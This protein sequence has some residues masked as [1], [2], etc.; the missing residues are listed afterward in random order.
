MS[1]SWIDRCW[2]DVIK[3]NVDDAISFF[4]PGLAAKRDYSNYVACHIHGDDEAN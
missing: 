1:E 3:E 2:K 4:M